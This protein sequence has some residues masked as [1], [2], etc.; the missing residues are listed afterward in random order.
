MDYIKKMQCSYH[1]KIH[2]D[3]LVFDHTFC[4]KHG[5]CLNPSRCPLI[6]YC[7]MQRNYKQLVKEKQSYIVQT[8]YEA[9]IDAIQQTEINMSIE[10]DENMLGHYRLL[11]NTLK[12][13]KHIYQMDICEI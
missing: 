1:G 8:E 5:H 13:L 12:N 6:K 2:S 11:L 7:P 4:I 10:Q 3:E 9:C